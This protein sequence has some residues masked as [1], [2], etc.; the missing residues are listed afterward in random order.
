MKSGIAA[1]IGPAKTPV[2]A[3]TVEFEVA[4][5]AAGIGATKTAA[6]AGFLLNNLGPHAGAGHTGPEWRT[7]HFVA[8][9]AVERVGGEF[10]FAGTRIAEVDRQGADSHG[11]GTVPQTDMSGLAMRPLESDPVHRCTAVGC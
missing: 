8:Q 4:A 3:G 6:V 7:V 10:G 9:R 1:N 5:V 2:V 11:H